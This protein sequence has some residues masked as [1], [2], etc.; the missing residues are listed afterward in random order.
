M[1]IAELARDRG[2]ELSPLK[3]RVLHFLEAHQEEVFRYRDEHLA[4]SLGEKVSSV[5]FA[6]GLLERDGIIDKQAVNGRVYFGSR[7]AIAA[8]RGRLGMSSGDPFED[9]RFIRDRAWART[10]DVDV[11]A[12]LDE[13]RGTWE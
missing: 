8:L 12:L 2:K 9:A 4:S 5:N 7:R 10:G 1:K 13:V 11:V 3:T 6:L